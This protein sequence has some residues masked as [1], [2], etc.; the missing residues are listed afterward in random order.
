VITELFW[1]TLTK[2]FFLVA[3]SFYSTEI[4]NFLPFNVLFRVERQPG[5]IAVMS[6]QYRLDRYYRMQR[7][8]S[9]ALDI[10]DDELLDSEVVG[11]DEVL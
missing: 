6:W 3:T 4:G 9:L 5:D 11:K 10:Q 2:F 7:Q 8:R 1:T